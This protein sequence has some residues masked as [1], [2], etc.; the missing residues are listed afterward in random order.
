MIFAKP[1]FYFNVYRLDTSLCPEKI[2]ADQSKRKSVVGMGDGSQESVLHFADLFK[3]KL[4]GEML[5]KNSS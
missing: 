2:W 1:I 3:Q 4:Y 5:K